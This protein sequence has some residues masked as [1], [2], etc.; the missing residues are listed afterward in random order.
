MADEQGVPWETCEQAGCIGVRL[1]GGKCLA[2]RRRARR[3]WI[4]RGPRHGRPLDVT[5]GVPITPALLHEIL[6]T[7]PTDSQRAPVPFSDAWFPQNDL[8]GRRAGFIG[9]TWTDAYGM[10][11]ITGVASVSGQF[12]VTVVMPDTYGHYVRASEMVVPCSWAAS[13]SAVGSCEVSGGSFPTCVLLVRPAQIRQIAST[14][15]HSGS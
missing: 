4:L 13:E 1:P 15:E 10:L 5:R 7:R 14:P 9:V 12:P 11:T 2:H 3:R 8:P 6:T